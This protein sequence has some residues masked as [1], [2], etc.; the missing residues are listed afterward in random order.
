MS[1]PM[2][3]PT[4]ASDDP[5][6][7]SLRASAAPRA[8]DQAA[9]PR[10]R[11]GADQCVLEECVA[12][13]TRRLQANVAL[14]DDDE[15]F[16]ERVRADIRALRARCQPQDGFAFQLKAARVLADFGFTTCPSGLM[17]P[18]A[19]PREAPVTRTFKIEHRPA[20]SGGN[21]IRAA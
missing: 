9:R 10:A 20:G 16:W 4:T 19:A 5:A 17:A 21:G 13:F 14:P 18:P 8:R 2:E 1:I 7:A 12:E 6:I 3:D 11:T 15:H